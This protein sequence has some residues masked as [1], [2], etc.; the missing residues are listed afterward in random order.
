MDWKI[1]DQINFIH[2][3]NHLKIEWKVNFLPKY[4][5]LWR[6]LSQWFHRNKY[7]D[8]RDSWEVV[9]C[10]VIFSASWKYWSQ[11]IHQTPKSALA[12]MRSIVVWIRFY[13]KKKEY[14]K[15]IITMYDVCLVVK[16]KYNRY[17][18]HFYR[19]HDLC[20]MG[21][22]FSG[23]YLFQGFSISSFKPYI[24]CVSKI[25]F[26]EKVKELP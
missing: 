14:P 19:P 22:R 15:S 8:N 20:A 25:Y 1:C 7:M 4:G 23:F 21:I 26:F 10:C 17:C 18:W 9:N 11:N 3:I 5:Q 13:N 24:T 16:H 12:F 2:G 6:L